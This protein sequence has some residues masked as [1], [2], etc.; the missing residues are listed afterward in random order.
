MAVL[1]MMVTMMIVG[2]K[3]GDDNEQTLN[4][5]NQHK[6]FIPS[7]VPHLALFSLPL[8][9]AFLSLYSN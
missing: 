4:W 2:N 8:L 7:M 1:V 5:S 3:G 9:F 6:E